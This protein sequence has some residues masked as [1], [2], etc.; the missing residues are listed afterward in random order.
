[1]EGGWEQPG[2]EEG[3]YL[4]RVK[5]VPMASVPL[6]PGKTRGSS[7]SVALM[8]GGEQLWFLGDRW[9]L[10]GQ[11]GRPGQVERGICGRP[12]FLLAPR[13]PEPPPHLPPWRMDSLARPAPEEQEEKAGARASAALVQVGLFTTPE[14]SPSSQPCGLLGTAGTP[15][16]PVAC[17]SPCPPG[18]LLS[19]ALGLEPRALARW[20]SALPL[21]YTPAPLS[22]ASYRLCLSG[23]PWRR[24]WGHRDYLTTEQSLV[25]RRRGPVQPRPPGRSAAGPGFLAGLGVLHLCHLPEKGPSPAL[26][27]RGAR[28]QATA[29]TA[30]SEDEG[31]E[32]AGEEGLGVPGLGFQRCEVLAGKGRPCPQ[33]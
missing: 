33:E 9:W 17:G 13:H 29:N 21:S 20:A 23:K 6:Q 10:V 4:C 24:R 16:P 15:Q 26:G 28:A 25:R 18:S 1:M 2:A 11:V 7:C 14:P 22:C 32:V 30:I 27:S 3:S 5:K 12:S 19:V 8:G 31:W